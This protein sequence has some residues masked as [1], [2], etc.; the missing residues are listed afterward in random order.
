MS[1]SGRR[2][3]TLGKPRKSTILLAAGVLLVLAYTLW[4]FLWLLSTSFK[5]PVEI[6]QS[7][8]TFVPHV[9]TFQN[10]SVILHGKD[11]S[12]DSSYPVIPAFVH[13][14]IVALATTAICTIVAS[15]AGYSLARRRIRL[16]SWAVV[17]I[18]VMRTIPRI[19]IAVPLYLLIDRLGLVDTLPGL[20]L[21]HITVVLPLATFLMYSFLQEIPEELEHAALV[22]GATRFGAF[23]RVMVPIAMP[24]IAVTAILGFILSYNEFLYSLILVST[25]RSMTLPVALSSFILAYGIKWNLLAAAG[26]FAVVP[27]MLFAFIVQ[28]HIARGL[29]FGAVK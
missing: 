11:P 16:M 4:P 3:P 8:P 2:L 24:G 13:S 21:A 9:P 10:Y 14:C 19:S 1:A 25:Q 20:I 29:S 6:F 5:Y 28:R 15:C 22:D 17:L 7:P 18:L 26:I 12:T 27:A 23:I